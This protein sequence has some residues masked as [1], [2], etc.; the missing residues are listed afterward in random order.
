MSLLHLVTSSF[1]AAIDSTHV[2]STNQNQ[3]GHSVLIDNG[4]QFALFIQYFQSFSK[5]DEWFCPD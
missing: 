4:L 5:N 3:Q 2:T 1:L